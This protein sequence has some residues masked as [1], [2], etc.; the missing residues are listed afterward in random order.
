MAQAFSNSVTVDR[1]LRQR[2]SVNYKRIAEIQEPESRVN[3][4]GVICSIKKSPRG[5]S[6]HA[7][8]GMKDE[9]CQPDQEFRL[10]LFF[11]YDILPPR[12][13]HGSILRVHKMKIELFNGV[14][15]G[16]VF[17]AADVVTFPP[18]GQGTKDAYSVN[19][20]FSFCDDDA[21]RL[22][23]LRRWIK[24]TRNQADETLR[25]DSEVNA[26]L[27]Q[28]ATTI[29]PSSPVEVLC[30]NKSRSYCQ[31]FAV[32]QNSV[33]G[34]RV[35]T[36][37][38]TESLQSKTDEYYEELNPCRDRSHRQLSLPTENQQRPHSK[39]TRGV[40]T[41]ST[42]IRLHSRNDTTEMP[43][44]STSMSNRS[45]SPIDRGE[46]YDRRTPSLIDEISSR[47][48]SPLRNETSGR[49]ISSQKDEICS[50]YQSSSRDETCSN[51]KSSPRD[52]TCIRRASSPR[53]ETCTRRMPSSR[54]E[55]HTRHIPSP[56][57]ETYSRNTSIPREK[58]CSRHAPSPRDE[59]FSRN[60]PYPK[61]KNSHRCTS[62]SRDKTCSRHMSPPRNETC[63]RHMSPSRNQNCSR[64]M[65]PSRNQ[66]CS[67]RM[68]PSR[69]ETCSRHISPSRT[70]NCSRLMSP[71]RSEM[72][73]R[74]LS[75]YETCS[76]YLSSLSD[77]TC[78]HLSPVNKNYK[79][80]ESPSSNRD[81]NSPTHERF[82]QLPLPTVTSSR[83]HVSVEENNSKELPSS[84]NKIRRS[85]FSSAAAESVST[86]STNSISEHSVHLSSSE[87]L[88]SL[89]NIESVH[90]S[91]SS[92]PSATRKNSKEVLLK[93][94][95]DDGSYTLY[96]MV[97]AVNHLNEKLVLT[98]G[99]GTTFSDLSNDTLN[100][101]KI[102]VHQPT[103]EIQTLKK[104]D[105]VKLTN[106][107]VNAVI[108][109]FSSRTLHPFFA[110]SLSH[111]SSSVQILKKNH[112]KAVELLRRL[113]M[114]TNVLSSAPPSPSPPP[115]P[116]QARTDKTH[117][118]V[119]RKEVNPKKFVGKKKK[120]QQA[121]RES[122]AAEKIEEDTSIQLNV[123][124][125][126]ILK[127]KDDDNGPTQS[128]G[129]KF[130]RKKKKLQQRAVRETSAAEKMEEDTSIQPNVSSLATLT[131]KD[132]DNGP[133]QSADRKFVGKKKK[134]K[135]RAV[136]ETSAAEKMEE[137]TSI[138]PNVSS[139]ATLTR[140]DDDNGPTRSADRNIS[141]FDRQTKNAFTQCT[142]YEVTCD[143]ERRKT[144]GCDVC[145]PVPE[146]RNVSTQYTHH[147]LDEDKQNEKN[148]HVSE[149]A[150][151]CNVSSQLE[152]TNKEPDILVDGIDSVPKNPNSSPI[153]SD[154]HTTTPKLNEINEEKDRDKS[155][156][157]LSSADSSGKLSVSLDSLMKEAVMS[158]TNPMSEVSPLQIHE[159]DARVSL[160]SISRQ[161][162][163][164]VD[165]CT[166]RVNLSVCGLSQ[167]V[168]PRTEVVEEINIYDY[169]TPSAG[170]DIEQ[171]TTEE[172]REFVDYDY[173]WYSQE[174]EKKSKKKY[175][176]G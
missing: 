49:H 139:L 69:D 14:L 78:K 13:E 65:S 112:A 176:T 27:S 102:A 120:L 145:F 7:V 40:L 55:T 44:W 15:D 118:I 132:D 171:S 100:E 31:L 23:Q 164:V 109:P 95:T 74:L 8:V 143:S 63:S 11:K 84:I 124:S 144:V 154:C 58:N 21:K 52:E 26:L 62:P 66:N 128:T 39:N 119:K 68:S 47:Q 16:R 67:R 162:T 175:T 46:T 25:L 147:F 153:V 137:D 53:D 75:S 32:P 28:T 173:P 37:A 130:V 59:T 101:V 103:K 4:Y 19:S 150:D 36:P 5:S 114:M 158:P 61:D 71:A 12:L 87:S 90:G 81:L 34:S 142:N 148:S 135:Q 33:P 93:E 174:T 97:F 149:E 157:T 152:K 129:R 88:P 2:M 123:S 60:M 57:E 6:R 3:M 56:R 127:R 163:S 30:S 73:N 110:F 80:S 70:E 104:G 136:R 141:S 9:T 140:K 121:V 131:R 29:A 94:V 107:I 125:S 43:K 105:V 82:N 122:S 172:S 165:A 134:L 155:F 1:P 169:V 151:D 111:S 83:Q 54:D 98:V 50:R 48:T 115:P 166:D 113:K 146:T 79:S 51:H 159:D 108:L 138:Q 156:T 76:T 41:C 170:D 99:D 126:A 45:Y 42:P 20:T 18:D 86:T 160:P 35:V 72:F 117:L 168:S 77:K 17:S 89:R 64:H 38:V 167:Y 22:S 92:K 85:L 133:T 116:P 10:H 106:V 96:C 91:L 161:E 24:S